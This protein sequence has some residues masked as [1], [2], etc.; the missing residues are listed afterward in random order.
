M[1]NMTQRDAFWNRV[2]E[3]Q[4]ERG[5]I[6]VVSADMGAPALDQFRKDFPSRWVNVGIAEQNGILVSSGLAMTG[7]RVFVYAIAP[8]I[9]LRCIEQTRVNSGIM[10]IPITIVGVSGG[11]GYIDAGPTHHS[12]EDLTMMRAMPHMTI[13]SIS[14]NTMAAA[15]ADTSC[16]MKNTN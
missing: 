10:N 8:F 11:F 12:T 5:D 13:N 2:Y 3:L 6:V 16:Q 7:Y 15:A 14:D 9:T 1:S 4:K